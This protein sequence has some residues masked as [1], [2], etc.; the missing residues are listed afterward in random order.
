MKFIL[1]FLTILFVILAA[2]IDS[3][4]GFLVSSMSAKLQLEPSNESYAMFSF[5]NSVSIKGIAL[6]IT[7]ICNLLIWRNNIIRFVR[8]TWKSA[9]APAAAIVVLGVLTGCGPMRVDPLDNIDT[10]ETA[11]VI[12]LEGENKD[13]QKQFESIE[14]LDSQKVAS[15]RVTIPQKMRQTGRLWMDYEWVPTIRVVKVN[16]TPV[17]R[18]W[19]AEAKGQPIAV[20]S[21]DS[22]G[23]SIG[24]NITAFIEEKDTAKFLYYHRDKS[25]SAVIDSNIR[26]EI[27]NILSEEAARRNLEQCKREKNEIFEAAKKRIIPFAQKYGI[28]ICSFGIADGY[29]Y[30]D[31]KVQDAI[32]AAYVYE[33]SIKSEEQKKT[34]QE[35]IN[36]RLLSI[37]EN[38]RKQAEEFAKA[39]EARKK[40][41]ETEIIKM[42]AE[43]ML[44]F[45]QKWNGQVPQFMTLGGGGSGG[46]PFLMN[47]DGPKTKTTP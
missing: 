29:C 46:M 18:E 20:E 45:A 1:T 37:A 9:T 47:I 7:V 28:T 23:F 40:Q 22:I 14:Y 42:Q 13:S 33:M 10:N 32:N 41:V 43:A 16:R 25:L 27:Q 31:P 19:T 36:L 26:G 39:S 21:K 17:T 5:L 11:F 34:A 44:T 30:D 4:V 3:R 35:Q 6:W 8:S 24:V 12:P 2:Y 38:E 15:K